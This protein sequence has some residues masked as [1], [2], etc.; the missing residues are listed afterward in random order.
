M[1]QLFPAANDF[2]KGMS[3][4]FPRANLLA[5]EWKRTKN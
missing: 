4:L 3:E 5:M 1:I 2:T